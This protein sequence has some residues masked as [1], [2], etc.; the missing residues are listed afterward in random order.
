[1]ASRPKSTDIDERE[2]NIAREREAMR[3]VLQ[4]ISRS[5]DDE[6]PVFDVILENA[7]RLCD[8]QLAF[9]TM[10]N[11]GRT[12]LE[13]KGS[14]GEGFESFVQYLEGTPIPLDA[15]ASSTA[16]S[17]LNC[18]VISYDDY[19]NGP[20]ATEAT[21]V[22]RAAIE[23][24]G[25][26][27]VVCVPLIRDGVG[28]G[29]LTI[30]RKEVRPFAPDQ[31]ALVETFAAQAVIAIENVRQFR[32]LQSRLERE[33]A[34]SGILSVIS[35]SPD[36][37]SPVFEAIHEHAARL[38]DAPF[39]GLFLT[40]P[41]GEHLNLLSHV[42]ANPQY[43]VATGRKWPLTDRSAMARAVIRRNVVHIPDMRDTAGYRAGDVETVR[44]ADEEGIRT[45]LAVPLMHHDRAIGC[46]GMYR[47]EV[48]PFSDDQ[49]NLVR[50]FAA[51]AVI[52]IQNVR[53]F[54]EIQQANAELE[55]RLER[56]A[57]SREILQV[58]SRSRDDE[59]P[60]F[61]VILENAARLCRAPQAVLALGR[62]GD[63]VLT[64]GASIGASPGTVELFNSGQMPM[65]PEISFSAKSIHECRVIH[66]ANMGESQLYR[67]G[68]PQVRR[69][70]DQEGIRT[71]LFV[72]L[73]SGGEAIGVITLFRREVD[74]FEQRNIE[75]VETF[76]AQAVIAI[77]N[78]RQFRELQTR[79]EREAATREILQVISR[80]R[81]HEKPVFDMILQN[82][83]RLC[84]APLA[85]LNLLD[86]AGERLI[87]Q[88]GWGERLEEMEE[89]VAEF[90]LDGKSVP[91]TAVRESRLVHIRDMADTDA[92][93][94]GDPLRVR[95]VDTHGIRSFLA[96]PLLRDGKAIGCIDL[97]RREVSPFEDRHVELIETFAA[98]AVIAIENVRQ[99]RAV[100]AARD[101]AEKALADLKKAQERLIQAEKMA[102]LGQLTAGIAHEIKNP[103]NFVNNFARLSGEL[104]VEL[105]EIL[106][107]P[108]AALDE[109]D[110]ED[111]EDLFRT[112]RDNLDKINQHGRRA[113]GI[114]K[115]MLLH[116]REGPSQRG[117]ARVNSIAK[118]ALNLAYHGA[119]AENP[120]FNIEMRT[121]LAEEVGVIECYPQ[122]LMRVFLNIISNGMYAEWGPRRSGR[123]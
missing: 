96:V 56:E 37:D 17:V 99:F 85:S 122:D 16:R 93:R 18:E 119:R 4:V 26:R 39:S 117:T 22:A 87:L 114:V 28:I 116:S 25:V 52:A 98:Q 60:V 91:A 79:L 77:E 8:A 43:S 102:S 84:A 61:D 49:I 27:S 100:I 41:D 110:R 67:N 109:E 86:E 15:E 7:A 24:T 115:N 105:G 70:V 58:I 75:L 95:A 120:S 2:L 83:A 90:P 118:E 88:A 73:I 89:G 121:D 97:F 72:P 65:D 20:E 94:S 81:D 54:R 35:Q 63:A 123:P 113:D 78:V 5:R 80:S 106:E 29:S 6:Q 1:L 40:D 51:Q 11:P 23:L 107:E 68:S 46:I 50:T 55:T 48:R 76:A 34:T 45:F 9:A 19:L 21:D 103:L 38:C 30:W 3:E 64:M 104:L 33:E 101:D 108:I 92:Y 112:V 13:F 42:G 47:R 111:A 66:L 14:K 10:V 32:E 53:Q 82:A 36:D 12:L 59:Q 44:A 69:L 62:K 74:P 31:I 71:I 57:A